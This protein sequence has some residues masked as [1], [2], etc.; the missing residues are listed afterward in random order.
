MLRLRGDSVTFSVVRFHGGP[1]VSSGTAGR[2]VRLDAHLAEP[3]ASGQARILSRS[4]GNAGMVAAGMAR[5]RREPWVIRLYG[6]LEGGVDREQRVDV[7]EFGDLVQ[8][9]AGPDRE[10]HLSAPG[11]CLAMG[12]EQMPD[13]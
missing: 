10:S 4:D 3:F 6:A 13:G 1:P 7:G 11:G 12:T 8:R 9:P 2:E 5:D